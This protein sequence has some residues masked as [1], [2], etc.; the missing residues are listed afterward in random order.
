M[1]KN[2]YRFSSVWRYHD[3]N[4]LLDR[5]W[6]LLKESKFYHNGLSDPFITIF[7]LFFSQQDKVLYSN[8]I[9]SEG[10]LSLPKNLL[11]KSWCTHFKTLFRHVV[12][13]WNIVA[14][15]RQFDKFIFLNYVLFTSCIPR[16][17]RGDFI[18]TSND[19]WVDIHIS[20]FESLKCER[21]NLTVHLFWTFG[22]WQ[23]VSF[24]FNLQHTASFCLLMF[25]S[26]LFLFWII[27]FVSFVG[28]FNLIASLCG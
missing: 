21:Y 12:Q 19:V 16:E 20:L 9:W 18:F 17:V 7:E 10:S 14:N 23:S 5:Y 15:A 4:L 2:L 22:S 28:F 11:N 25:P 1:F 3:Y 26:L 13:C 27:S 8:L 6:F 24:T